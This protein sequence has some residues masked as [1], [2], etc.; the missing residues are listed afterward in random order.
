MPGY[1]ENYRLASISNGQPTVLN[2]LGCKLVTSFS[3][4]AQLIPPKPNIMANILLFDE[5]TGEL[6]A[7]LQANDITAWRTAAASIVATKHLFSARPSMPKINTV[8]IL[9]CGVQVKYFA[10]LVLNIQSNL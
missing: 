5:N 7:T 2:S 8:A 1:I 6:K 4:N 9:G 3:K 10:I